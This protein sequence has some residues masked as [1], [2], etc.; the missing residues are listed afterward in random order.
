MP[1]ILLS[2]PSHD[3]HYRTTHIKGGVPEVY[4]ETPRP[5]M[6]GHRHH[7]SDLTRFGDA[8]CHSCGAT[9]WSAWWVADGVFSEGTKSW[10]DM[11]ETQYRDR[12]T[13]EVEQ[14][15]QLTLGALTAKIEPV[16]VTVAALDLDQPAVPARRP[17]IMVPKMDYMRL[18]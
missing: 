1:M 18:S 13:T 8:V 15:L 17:G 16:T 4:V 9:A 7:F 14:R 2:N 3:A 5:W 11:M 10:V 12:F 6:E